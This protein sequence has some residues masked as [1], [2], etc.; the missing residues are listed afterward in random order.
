MTLILK[1]VGIGDEGEVDLHGQQRSRDK[2][3]RNP[4]T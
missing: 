1:G 4:F 3:K 2:R